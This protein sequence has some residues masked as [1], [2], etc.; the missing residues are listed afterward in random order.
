MDTKLL[1]KATMT[2]D[3]ASRL[4]IKYG[5]NQIEMHQKSYVVMFLGQFFNPMILLLAIGGVI[6]YMTGAT[7]ESYIIFTI[8]LLNTLLGFIQEFRSNS[9]FKKL[10][11]LIASDVE[12]MRDGQKVLVNK[13]DIVPG[14]YI[15]L[16]LGSIV[17]ADSFVIYDGNASIDESSITGESVPIHKQVNKKEDRN[18]KD[19]I[20]YAGTNI[21][22]GYIV[23]KV[24]ATGKE[25]SFGKTAQLTG[26]TKH[27]TEYEI[28]LRKLSKDIIIMAIISVA[29]IFILNSIF[30]PSGS[31]VELLMFTLAIAI[32]VIPEALP[33]IATITLSI[34][35]VRLGKKGAIVKQL[36]AIESLG[37]VD[38]ICTDKTGTLTENTL[39]L[40]K[41]DI[42]PK[43]KKDFYKYCNLIAK[44]S[45]DPFDIAINDMLE[46]ADYNDEEKLPEYWDIPFDPFKKESAREFD[47][48]TLIK[49]APEILIDECHYKLA[50][51]V[52]FHDDIEKGYRVLSLALKKG[53]KY[54]YIGTMF[55]Y[56][57]VKSDVTKT[58]KLAENHGIAIK[59]ITGD[60]L[61]I[62]RFVANEVGLGVS[63]EEIVEASDLIFS[64]PKILEQQVQ[65]YTV[66]C[67]ADPIQKYKI[68]EALQVNKTV[69]YLGDGINDAPSLK[70]ADVGIVVN[71]ATDIA[72]SAADVI[73]LNKNIDTIVTAIVEG[74]KGFENIE[75]YL[76]HTLT[77]NFGNFI[78]IGI[79]SLFLN[80]L[81]MLPL[82]ILISNLII[83]FASLSFSFDFVDQENLKKPLHRDFGQLITF[84]LILGLVTSLLDCLFF[85]WAGKFPPAEVQTLWFV[86]SGITELL[87]FYSLR[88]K[89]LFTKSR[90]SIA[91][92]ILVFVAVMIFLIIVITGIPGLNETTL[93]LSY[94]PI[95]LTIPL[96]YFMLTEL[97]KLRIIKYFKI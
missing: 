1:K 48:F 60:S 94:L 91:M 59:I 54:S 6:S 87:L 34:S 21:K 53:H 44:E 56:D 38:V 30:K 23:A 63:I 17:P 8:I 61:G 50:N 82:Q 51:N 97:I 57:P 14:D 25:S 24:F 75:K 73:L 12:V 26:E 5:K 10:S 19:G 45:T 3:E 29:I 78:T 92:H 37:N 9:I 7:S 47:D 27:L 74:R 64:E 39:R 13:S 67:R 46:L 72:K 66:F 71:N 31:L 69:A 16:R 28:N 36:S 55:F 79:I 89:R 65:K 15:F 68:I 83:D 84:S 81:P 4:L 58:I 96:V 77:G 43:F 86:T 85:V 22:S 33:A 18:F 80:F 88:T 35:A 42:N 70:L 20:L 49:G 41:T 52:S 76:I 32:T 40:I 11:K 62:S 90:P 93:N 95:I 2:S